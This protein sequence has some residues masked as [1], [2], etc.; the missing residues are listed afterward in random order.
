MKPSLYSRALAYAREQGV[1]L[2]TAFRILGSRGARARLRRSRHEAATRAACV[3]SL[4]RQ[5]LF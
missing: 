2:K 4:E 3:S 1:S 5:R